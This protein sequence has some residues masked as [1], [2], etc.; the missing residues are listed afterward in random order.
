MNYWLLHFYF[1]AGLFLKMLVERACE[2]M[3]GDS[4]WREARD[5]G[6]GGREWREFGEGDEAKMRG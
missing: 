2:E 3:E 1:V 6:S 4:E 5:G